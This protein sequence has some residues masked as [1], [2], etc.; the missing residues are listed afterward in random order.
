MAAPVESVVE[1]QAVHGARRRLGRG[2]SA[3]LDGLVEVPVRSTRAGETEPSTRNSELVNTNDHASA[4]SWPSQTLGTVQSVPVGVIASGRFQPRRTFDEASLNR[5]AESIRTAGVMQPVVL[6]RTA[7]GGL[8]LVAGERRW[9]AAIRAGLT[10]IPAVIHDLS[11]Q[12]AAELALIE[13]LQREDLN[14]IERAFAFRTLVER[15]G[16]TQEQ[17]ADRVGLDRASVANTMRLADL[18]PAIRD[19]IA[20]GRLSA[21]HGKALLAAS[22]GPARVALAQRAAEAGW[23]VR[24]LESAVRSGAST[25]SRQPATSAPQRGDI[26]RHALERRLSEHLGT[27]VHIATARGGTRG[28][29]TLAFYSLD[30]FDDLMSRLGLRVS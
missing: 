25:R 7:Q 8:E 17:L 28:T 13:N 26:E 29:I 30:H 16:L 19:M 21:G 18:E 9:R 22:P 23:S 20:G 3:M 4:T 10:H 1:A 27:R 12:A 24:R 11:D 14:P 5:L 2:L 6:R 15:F